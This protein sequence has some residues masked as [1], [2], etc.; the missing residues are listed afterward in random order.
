MVVNGYREDFLGV[1]LPNYMLIEV[2]FDGLRFYEVEGRAIATTFLAVSF[3][4]SSRSIIVL[5]TLTQES[6]INTLAGPAI[7]FRTSP[8]G[9]PQNEQKLILV[10]LAMVG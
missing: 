1:I 10:A 2:V 6:Q 7:I 5:H 4:P 8:C 9:L 3:S